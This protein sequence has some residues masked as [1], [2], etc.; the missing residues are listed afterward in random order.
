MES[1]CFTRLSASIREIWPARFNTF[2]SDAACPGSGFKLLL[3][4]QHIS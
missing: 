1:F 4:M 2:V 3:E